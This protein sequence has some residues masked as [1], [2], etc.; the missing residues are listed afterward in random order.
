MFRFPLSPDLTRR[1]LVGLED[2][3]P[4]GWSSGNENLITRFAS[5]LF[6]VNP[7]GV[8]RSDNCGFLAKT[9]YESY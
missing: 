9:W 6:N 3:C 5:C 4:T 8:S 2:V 1:W 7:V